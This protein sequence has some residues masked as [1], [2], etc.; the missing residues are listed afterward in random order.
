MAEVIIYTREQLESTIQHL[1]DRLEA[2][3]SNQ[4]QISNVGDS[5]NLGLERED[6]QRRIQRL[7]DRQ[8]EL[9]TTIYRSLDTVK[10]KSKPF[11]VQMLLVPTNLV[12]R[13]VSSCLR[14]I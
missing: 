7:N 2:L 1:E 4:N 13:T 12:W 8:N 3:A 6:L 14:I 9:F 10:I 5:N 11:R